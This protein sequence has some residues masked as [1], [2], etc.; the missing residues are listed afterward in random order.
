MIGEWK[1]YQSTKNI[2]NKDKIVILYHGWGGTA[3]GYIELA[4]EVAQEGYGVLIPDI[5]YHD[6][7]FPLEDHFDY[8][9]TQQYFWDTIF[10]TID[11]FND[12]LGVVGIKKNSIILIGNSMGGFIANG[13]FAKEPDIS[14][15]ANINGSGS[16]LLTEKL[17]R[18]R[19]DREE[20]SQEEEK[21]LK[22]YDP[23]NTT[24]SLSPV[25]LMHGDS[26]TIIPIE[27][28]ENYYK[29]LSQ[30]KGRTNVEW[31]IF[32]KVNHAFTPEMVE[33]LIAWL[34][35]IKNKDEWI[36]WT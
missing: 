35:E 7:R 8:N 25:L 4:E 28:Q 9:I 27:S 12:F 30:E 23:I 19:D 26:D 20:M 13:I 10:H 21:L 17:F 32:E 36:R 29:Y 3:K 22:K 18:I 34:K 2:Q 33:K 15:L 11:E 1:F 6:E 14:G 31:G 24:R 5:L 16:F